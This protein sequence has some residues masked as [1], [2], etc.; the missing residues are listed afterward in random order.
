MVRVRVRLTIRI[1][2]TI[3]ARLSTWRGVGIVLR[4]VCVAC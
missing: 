4:F 3:R 2:L 1:R